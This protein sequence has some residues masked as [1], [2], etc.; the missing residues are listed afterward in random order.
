MYMRQKIAT[1][2][3]S[4][5]EQH[6]AKDIADQLDVVVNSVY[7]HL[8]AMAEAN[9]LDKIDGKYSI[10]DAGIAHYGLRNCKPEAAQQGELEDATQSNPEIQ[11][12][13][14]THTVAQINMNEVKEKLM[15]QEEQDIEET[16][17][18][19]VRNIITDATLKLM[20]LYEPEPKPKVKD[21]D[22][23]I[24]LLADTAQRSDST[25]RSL[26]KAILDDLQEL[27]GSKIK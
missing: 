13:E 14:P 25:R 16:T 2:L 11:G 3:S 23:K 27:G 4:T 9:H 5:N 6:K 15:Q 22:A 12:F 24:A 21:L 1:Y 18:D 7:L 10:T 8:N 26:F 20:R 19:E 17:Y